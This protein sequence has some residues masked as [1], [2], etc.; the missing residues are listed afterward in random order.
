MTTREQLIRDIEQL[1]GDEASREDATRVYEAL[2]RSGAIEWDDL[3]GL[4]FELSAV[5]VVDFA[6]Q[7]LGED[8]V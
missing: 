4:R 5:D 2:R 6:A 3:H 7:L 8:T 1:L